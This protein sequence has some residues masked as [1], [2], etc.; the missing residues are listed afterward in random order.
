[1]LIFSKSFISIFLIWVFQYYSKISVSKNQYNKEFKSDI[2]YS[3]HNRVL[4]NTEWLN[5][6]NYTDQHDEI[7]NMK[8]KTKSQCG[9]TIETIS[10]AEKD[11]IK[12]AV[13]AEDDAEVITYKSFKGMDD[14]YD[15][16]EQ[17]YYTTGVKNNLFRRIARRIK[18]LD[19]K[20]E[21]KLFKIF[22]FIENIRNDPN[23]PESKRLTEMLKQLNEVSLPLLFIVFADLIILL[24]GTTPSSI[25]M[26]AILNGVLGTYVYK[27][28]NKF[29]KRKNANII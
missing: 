1:M 27:K 18:K 21:K 5:D 13:D 6:E 8:S 2:I 20:Y 23:I 28:H 12:T 15:Y 24:L 11:N 16:E 10:E 29:K 7:K 26:L 25:A 22:N 14:R 4:A 9:D 19:K 17:T 3:K